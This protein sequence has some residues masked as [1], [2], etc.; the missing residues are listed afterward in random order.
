MD[1]RKQVPEHMVIPSTS[2]RALPRLLVVRY[3]EQT[4]LVRFNN[5]DKLLVKE[6][7]RVVRS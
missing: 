3:L 7:V 1:P 2:F 6:V 4:L 5:P